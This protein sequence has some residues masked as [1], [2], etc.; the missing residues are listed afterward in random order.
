MH[1]KK[2]RVFCGR[3]TSELMKVDST[4][5]WQSPTP[6]WLILKCPVCVFSLFTGNVNAGYMPLEENAKKIGAKG[7]RIR[8][9]RD[10]SDQIPF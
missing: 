9:I 1:R 5:Q 6:K 7:Y 8:T 4:H 10:A 2:R 3:C